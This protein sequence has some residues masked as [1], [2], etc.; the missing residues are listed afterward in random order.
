MWVVKLK[1]RHDCTI[2]DRCKKFNC[3][4]FSLSLSNW[5]DKNYYYTSQR[6]TIEGNKKDVDKFLRELKK[7]ERIVNLEVSKN[8]VFFVERRK[9]AEIPSSHYNPK[10]FFVKPVFVDREGFEYWEMASWAKEILMKFVNDLKKE[11]GIKVVVERFQNVKLDSIYFPKIM[12][13]LSNK[14]KEAYQLAVENG[15]YVFPRKVDLKDLAILMNI[16][17]ST[18]QEHLRRAEEKI[19]PTYT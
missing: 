5:K 13:R 2:G 15:Y 10:M 19:M 3:I 9:R 8:T 11:K 4:S 12:P 16:S 17:V 18:F 6:H 7:D 1:I 14:Q